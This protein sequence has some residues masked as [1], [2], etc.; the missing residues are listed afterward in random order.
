MAPV[1][2][3]DPRRRDYVPSPLPSQVVHAVQEL[4]RARREV[5]EAHLVAVRT[6]SGSAPAP[7]LVVVALD[8][9]VEPMLA[10]ELRSL[11]MPRVRPEIVVL[12]PGDEDL[13][14]LRSLGGE[15]KRGDGG[16]RWWFL[17]LGI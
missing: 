1:M 10:Q 11:L 13:V 2:E 17:F 3:L 4:V 12:A 7:V 9:A 5:L 6:S 14:Q 16:F 15:L 8:H